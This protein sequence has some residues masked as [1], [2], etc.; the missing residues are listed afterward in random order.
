MLMALLA[1][2]GLAPALAGHDPC[3][4]PAWAMSMS[5]AVSCD[6]ADASKAATRGAGTY[7]G[8]RTKTAF[9][10]TPASPRSGMS[11]VISDRV[12]STDDAPEYAREIGAYGG[13]INESLQVK[14]YTGT[15]NSELRTWGVS[16]SDV[17][18]GTVVE[19]VFVPVK[20]GA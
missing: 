9:V 14:S 15:W 17:K 6:F 18:P 16:A 2:I 1:L 7:T 12:V 11:L 8:R 19:I 13:W 4:R 20:A 3:L 5:S 10:I